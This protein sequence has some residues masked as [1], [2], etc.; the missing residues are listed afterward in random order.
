MTTY[1]R[2]KKPTLR[3]PLHGHCRRQPIIIPDEIIELPTQPSSIALEIANV[4]AII[5]MKQ[6]DDDTDREISQNECEDR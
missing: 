3:E 4:R 6:D 2:I 1:R 5:L